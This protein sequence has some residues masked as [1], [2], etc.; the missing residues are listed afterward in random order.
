MIVKVAFSVLVRKKRKQS[1]FLKT[2]LGFIRMESCECPITQEIF[3]DPVIGEDGHTYER[4]AITDWL[5]KNGTSPM[6]RQP[7]SIDTL[8][9]NHVVK[10]MIEEYITITASSI[11]LPT[12]LLILEKPDKNQY[13]K[14]LVKQSMKLNGSIERI[15]P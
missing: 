10:Q 11:A 9:T 3:E 13:F 15:H 2:K 6:T 8:R 4:K 14:D 7:M 1:Q 12:E 5:R